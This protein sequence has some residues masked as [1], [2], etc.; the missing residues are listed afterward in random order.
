[1][2]HCPPS[3]IGSP[4]MFGDAWADT[5]GSSRHCVLD[6]YVAWQKSPA[7]RASALAMTVLLFMPGTVDASCM[8]GSGQIAEIPPPPAPPEFPSFQTIPLG[9]LVAAV[10]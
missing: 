5:S 2:N 10:V 9:G 3:T 7:V 8:E 4:P 1:M 6:P